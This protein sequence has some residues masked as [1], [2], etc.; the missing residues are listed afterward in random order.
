M[1]A[2]DQDI[3]EDPHLPPLRREWARDLP[4][5][6]RQYLRQ[7]R[8]EAAQNYIPARPLI[9]KQWV[10]PSDYIPVELRDSA[11]DSEEA[12]LQA[13]SGSRDALWE[14]AAARPQAGRNNQE[15]R[16]ARSSPRAPAGA[17]GNATARGQG[18]ERQAALS[19][20]A[21]DVASTVMSHAAGAQQSADGCVLERAA[22]IIPFEEGGI[23]GARGMIMQEAGT[24]SV[25]R[26]REVGLPEEEAAGDEDGERTGVEKPSTEEKA[27]EWARSYTRRLS[28]SLI[29]GKSFL[30]K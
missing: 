27:L 13:G 21:S 22:H 10:Q 18:G 17:A 3:A 24:V 30:S 8:R 5:T 9:T 2:G 14:G 15:G 29:Q 6:G 12:P 16:A 19:D 26:D 25:S 23:G 4:Q 11:G 20:R 1:L 28:A 7:V